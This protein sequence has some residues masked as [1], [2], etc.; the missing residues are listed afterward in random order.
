MKFKSMKKVVAILTM[1]AMVG[2]FTAGCGKSQTEETKS[3]ATA[4]TSSTGGEVDNEWTLITLE[5]LTDYLSTVEKPTYNWAYVH[6]SNYFGN[7]I[8]GELKIEDNKFYQSQA[9]EKDIDIYNYEYE[10]LEFDVYEWQYVITKETMENEF[11]SAVAKDNGHYDTTMDD[12]NLDV[13]IMKNNNNYIKFEFTTSDRANTALYNEY[14]Y[15]LSSA[16]R[17]VIWDTVDLTKINGHIV[18]EE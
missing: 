8:Y 2:T 1:A 9:H 5:E 15:A 12:I 6:D 3:N 17:E 10:W 7:E 18:V 16:T 14:G 4:T 13:V 11:S